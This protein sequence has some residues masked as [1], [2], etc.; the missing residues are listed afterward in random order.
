MGFAEAWINIQVIVQVIFDT[1]WYYDTKSDSLVVNP[2]YKLKLL[3]RMIKMPIW[4]L[5][6]LTA[7]L[8]F[9]YSTTQLFVVILA[10]NTETE[11]H[12]KVEEILIN[13]VLSATTLLAIVTTYSIHAPQ[14]T[15]FNAI[16]KKA[17]VC[18]V[19]NPTKHRLPDQAELLGYGLICVFLCFPVVAAASPFLINND[20]FN[21]YLNEF[22]PTNYRHVLAAFVYGSF[23]L[24]G[25]NVL[26]SILIL[27]LAC[28]H[29]F[30]K[31]SE[32]NL[33]FTKGVSWQ[34]GQD[35][36]LLKGV[37]YLLKVIESFYP[38]SRSL[39]NRFLVM[40]LHHNSM[41][42]LMNMSNETVKAF[43]PTL[44]GVGISLCV[45]SNY[46]CVAL[47]NRE[48]YIIKLIWFASLG[49]MISVYFQIKFFCQHASTPLLYTQETIGY[50]KVQMI[51]LY[52][53]KQVR[54]M[55]PYGFSMGLLFKVKKLV[56]L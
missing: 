29:I 40:K 35:K 27:E 38:I 17:G 47:Y 52:G 12:T 44:T 31:Q 30:E 3:H 56:E 15:I 24:V 43:L 48:E 46:V 10:V 23:M 11:T 45:I 51:S 54:A 33:R 8:V 53:R 6:N 2:K 50:W 37:K 39:R 13:W 16:L 36:T 9:V 4:T 49:I 55:K 42:L 22:I 1:P 14:I 19:G 26:A 34:S 32:K 7:I 21:K 18:N 25:E 5:Y 41:L 20:P 28:C